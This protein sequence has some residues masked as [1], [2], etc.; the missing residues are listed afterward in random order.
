[1]ASTSSLFI[2]LTGLNANSRNID[3]I[4]NNI[5]NVNTAGY[6]S[7]RLN[8]SNAFSRTIREG[9]APDGELGGA[10]P[11]QS[12]QGV[13]ISGT[14]RNFSTGSLSATGDGRD[15]A[16]EGKGMFIVQRGI[17][18]LYTRVG[19][20]RTDSNNNLTTTDGDFVL[21]YPVDDEFNLQA[22]A[23]GQI[24]IPVGTLTV[25]E[26]TR[27]VNLSGNLDA[28]GDVA[29]AG[30]RTNFS[31]Q[32]GNGF[33]V[34][35]TSTRLPAA[36]NLLE[37]TSFFTDIQDPLAPGARLFNPGETIRLTGVDRGSGQLPDADFE[38][39]ATTTVQDF[40]DFFNDALR[41]DTTITNADG[42]TPGLTIDP[43][44]GQ[45]SL[46]SE[47]GT[48]NGFTFDAQDIRVLDDNG[49]LIRQPF[50]PTQ[51]SDANGE[52]VRTTM[53]VYDSLGTPVQIDLNLTLTTKDTT[54]TT[55]TYTAES[56]DD[57]VGSAIA[58]TGTLRFDT[59][60]RLIEPNSVAVAV[61]RAGTGAASP[62]AVTLN[63]ETEG[64]T[65]TSLTDVESTVFS[66]G[67]DGAPIGTLSSYSVAPDGTILGSFTNQQTRVLGQV[68]VATFTVPEALV[69]LSDNL[70]RVGPNSG[71]PVITEPGRLGSGRLVS[72]SLELSNVELGDEFI[73]LILASTG[74]S[75]SSRVIRTADELLQQLLVLG[76]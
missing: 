54:G 20:F 72:G 3:V 46:I 57:T 43:V 28:S 58:G 64:S 24:S 40:I 56:D 31:D 61:D 2:G 1:M 21:G 59:L 36:P 67:Q 16:I 23:I 34:V 35:P 71:D 63:F 66:T 22:G 47:A 15:L 60:G 45:F 18:Q 41:I 68:A 53:L 62:L 65:L 26:A 27:N 37:A 11:Y 75:A 50:L 74:Y 25:A 38:L 9:T 69:E 49:V 14:L 5:A 70:Y 33:T 42:T 39:T 55:W 73:N 44:T 12:G 8:F 76:R 17:D 19:N 6:K 4:G 13:S 32:S 51:V 10:N 29:T 7:A 52:S 30:S 48:E